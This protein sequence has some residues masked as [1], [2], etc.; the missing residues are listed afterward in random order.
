MESTQLLVSPSSVVTEICDGFSCYSD[1]EDVVPQQERFVEDLMWNGH[2]KNRT[3]FGRK[4]QCEG[5]S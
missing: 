4:L 5:G 3:V 1:W 2:R